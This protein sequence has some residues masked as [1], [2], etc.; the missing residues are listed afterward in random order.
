ME[1]RSKDWPTLKGLGQEEEHGNKDW[2]G[3]VNELG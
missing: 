1:N 2:D 3:A